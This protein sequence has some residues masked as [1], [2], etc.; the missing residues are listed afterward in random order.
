[1][2]PSSRVQAQRV[3]QHFSKGAQSYENEAD[4]HLELALELQS[5]LLT[6]QLVPLKILEIGSHTGLL[7]RQIRATYPKAQLFCVDLQTQGQKKNIHDTRTHFVQ[8]NGEQLPFA[9]QTFNLIVSG[10]TFQWF[11]RWSE[12]LFDIYALLKPGGVLAFSQFLKPTLEPLRQEAE[13]IGHANSFLDMMEYSEVLHFLKNISSTAQGIFFE[14]TYFH[15]HL[16]S[17]LKHLRA[18]GV[19]ASSQSEVAWTRSQ[20]KSWE[21]GLEKYRTDQGLPLYY[22]AGIYQVR[23]PLV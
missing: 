3:A 11:E 1:M 16:R 2:N 18:M 7:S 6:L 8:T 10:A 14:K 17:I 22:G 5:Q 9:P 13:K 12:S 15:S 19:G 23:R 20:I 4:F 21:S